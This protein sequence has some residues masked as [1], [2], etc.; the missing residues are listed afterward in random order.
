VLSLFLC[1]F[2]LLGYQ[3][4]RAETYGDFSYEIISLGGGGSATNESYI[5]ISQYNGS[6]S[7]VTIPDNINGIPVSSIASRAFSGGYR[8]SPI[9]TVNI[10]NTIK[11]IGDHAFYSCI[12][13]ENL[14]IPSQ[15]NYIGEG[16]FSECESL[17]TINVDTNNPNFISV[18][19][20]LFNKDKT[21]LLQF[22][23]GKGGTYSIPDGVKNLPWDAFLSCS[24][25]TQVTLPTS[26]TNIGP[27][28]FNACR[29]LQT[30]NIPRGITNINDTTF[31]GCHKLND[32]QI[33]D[34][35]TSIGYFAFIDCQKLTNIIIPASVAKIN[36]YSFSQC[37]ELTSVT[38]LGDCPS[39]QPLWG[40]DSEVFSGSTKTTVYFNS[41]SSGWSST[42]CGRPATYFGTSPIV[43]NIIYNSLNCSVVKTPNKIYFLPDDIVSITATPK[44]GYLFVSWGGDTST[45]STSLNLTMNT[46]KTINVNIAQDNEDADGDGLTNY[47]ECV[48]YGSNPNLKD[49][50]GDGVEDGQATALGYNPLF[51]F[52]PL[53]NYL[54]IHPPQGLYT[55][56]QIEN[57]AM[58]NLVINKN[59][60]GNF[61]LNYDIE[62]STDLLTWT[63]YQA[64]SLPLTGL[65]TNKAFVRIKFKNNQ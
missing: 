20:V 14:L 39:V 11:T 64:L 15:V 54:R 27:S 21:V 9:V 58:G 26:V 28:C 4:L 22:P 31:A 24:N 34:T 44:P 50:N 57:M 45:T 60:N 47:Q 7:S 43:L 19:G 61:T 49:T 63:P 17:N 65:P 33:P 52:N 55:S 62:Q 51:N 2:L 3:N 13:L 30:I 12:K 8:S 29:N 6:S 16:A 42:F 32:I 53:I 48:I 36:G 56:N 59:T 35:V 25:L 37:L 40:D 18:D 5:Q 41:N 38:F 23:A 1:F 46:S 10:P